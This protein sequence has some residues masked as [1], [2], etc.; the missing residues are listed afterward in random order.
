MKFAILKKVV[1]ILTV[2]LSF[3]FVNKALRLI[4]LK[5]RA[6]MNA[7]MS[8]FVICVEAIIYLL[9]YNLH[10]CTFNNHVSN[11]FSSSRKTQTKNF[12]SN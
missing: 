3:L 10:D 6:A 5:A 8:L 4:N 2:L 11:T 12:N 7:K 9:L 1:C